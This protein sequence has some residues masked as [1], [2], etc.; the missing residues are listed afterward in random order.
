MGLGTSTKMIAMASYLAEFYQKK[1]LMLSLQFAWN[2]MES[3]VVGKRKKQCYEKLFAG[4]GLEGL[5]KLAKSGLLEK[6]SA[7]HCT[8]R[9]SEYLDLLPG[10]YPEQTAR[11]LDEYQEVLPRLMEYL[12]EQYEL[13]F[14]DV[15]MAPPEFCALVQKQADGM[16]RNLNQ[17]VE[18]VKHYFARRDVKRGLPEYYVFGCYDHQS[19][20]NLN[21]LRHIIR[22]LNRGN[23]AAIPYCTEIR[24]ACQDGE[25]LS[26]ISRSQERDASKSMR[27]FFGFLQDAAEG[28][29]QF[30]E[31]GGEAA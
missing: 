16:V 3:Y 28:F 27:N 25:L 15:A 14:C 18:A 19:K 21:N 6:K 26:A 1:T 2:S 7:E 22:E 4:I 9:C 31:R 24:D 12:E 11:V 23:S 17:N 20:Y 29:L 13:V 10:Y 8:F 30:M 5:R